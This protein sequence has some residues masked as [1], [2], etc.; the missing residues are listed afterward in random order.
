MAPE[1]GW[2]LGSGKVMKHGLTSIQCTKLI[3][4]APDRDAAI[5]RMK[6]ACEDFVLLGYD[7]FGF[8][9]DIMGHPN[10]HAGDTTT[11]FIELIGLKVGT[12]NLG[13]YSLCRCCG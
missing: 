2:T 10:Y 5:R 9:C 4:H 8:L 13:Y 7:E 1:S 6:R 12:R 11:D 3:V